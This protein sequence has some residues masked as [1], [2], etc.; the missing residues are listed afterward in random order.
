MN[1]TLIYRHIN[2][3]KIDQLITYFNTSNKVISYYF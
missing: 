1:Y 2:Y 3:H